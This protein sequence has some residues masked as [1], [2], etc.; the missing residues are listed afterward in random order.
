MQGFIVKINIA[1]GKMEDAL[2]EYRST[3]LPAVREHKGYVS[4]DLFVDRERNTVT[5]L[6]KWQSG[7]GCASSVE[8]YFRLQ[9][10]KLSYC[11]DPV[12]RP[13]EFEVEGETDVKL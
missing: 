7:P 5:W 9:R 12:P 13:E 2:S 1:P 11:L 3:L 8:A 10:G 6:G 4:S